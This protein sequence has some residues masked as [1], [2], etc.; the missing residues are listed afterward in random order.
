MEGMPFIPGNGGKSVTI[1][2]QFGFG[3]KVGDYIFYVWE[4]W[5]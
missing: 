5:P 4:G 1:L 3:A 2:Q